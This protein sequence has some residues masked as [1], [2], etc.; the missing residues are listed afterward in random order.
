VGDV[1]AASDDVRAYIGVEILALLENPDFT[2]A[3][4]G[5]LLPDPAS[6][7]RRS[8]LEGRLHSLSIP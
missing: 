1:A 3:L 4:A 8:I 2:E 5:F 6:Q 7:A